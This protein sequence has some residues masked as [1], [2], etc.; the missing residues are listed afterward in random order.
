MRFP[1]NKQQ[2]TRPEE[3]NVQECNKRTAHWVR[4]VVWELLE[5]C[6]T[7]EAAIST[8]PKLIADI[9]QPLGI[10]R[11]RAI[12]IQQFSADYLMK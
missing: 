9:I 1:S 4:R 3:E 6:P 8:D 7:P 5:L 2:L 12:D 10:Y 11:K